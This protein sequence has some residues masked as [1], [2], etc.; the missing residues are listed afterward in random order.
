MSELGSLVAS[1]RAAAGLTQQEIANTLEL[2]QTKISRLEGGDGKLEEYVAYLEAIDTDAA[3]R[4]CHI[5]GVKWAHLAQPNL[6]NPDLD[7]LVEIEGALCRLA[8][9]KTTKKVP[10]VLVGQAELL[11]R[12]LLEFGTYLLNVDHKLVWIGEIGVGKTTGACVQAGLIT[13]PRA[14]N[15]L[16][17]VMLDTGGGRTTL[18]DVTVERGPRYALHVIP[19]SDEEVYRLA[20]EFCRGLLES[21]DK[22]DGSVTADFKPAEEVERAL[23]SMANLRRPPRRKGESTPLDPAVEL[24]KSYPD[25]EE[26]RAEVSSRLTLWRRTRKSIEFDGGD[27]AEGRR[28]LKETF[29]LINN[30]RHPEFTLPAKIRVIVPF[31]PVTGSPF[32]IT[33][34]DTRGV[35]GTSIRPDLVAHLKNNRAVTILC[36]RWGSAPEPSSQALLAHVRDTEADPSLL[37]R[38]AIL[39]LARG[40]EALSMRHDDGAAATDEWE[41]YEIKLTHVGDALR[42]VDL[43]GINCTAFDAANDDPAQLTQYLIDRIA[44]LRA[45]QA[46][47]AL[48]AVG[49]VGQ[50][51]ENVKEAQALAVL[52]DI[53]NDLQILADR[54]STPPTKARMAVQNRLLKAV[55]GL[56]ARIIWA[57]T[58]RSGRYWNFNVYQYLGDGAAANAKKNCAAAIGGIREIVE[59]RLANKEYASAKAFLNQILADV[60]NWEADY[61]NAAR[62]H[63]IATFERKLSSASVMWDKCERHYGRGGGYREE[64]AAE[65]EKWFEENELLND[66]F[67]QLLK[68]AW[69]TSII[70]PLSRAAGAIEVAGGSDVA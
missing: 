36:S 68:K 42:R 7:T 47:G 65:L 60:N 11:S 33:M 44:N 39:V 67:E 29:T 3:R 5:V 13:D 53:N 25:A 34:M 63:A 62:H 4:L 69:R 38:V 26:F 18:C 61:V 15:D 40:G 20:A 51:L 64:V 30:G 49:A 48:A 17:G 54:H 2:T 58:R 31:E 27:D 59:Q 70:E 22:R 24:A 28:W 52:Q 46:E 35:D 23:R 32:N 41:G 19:L 9:F 1:V 37:G 50:M 45:I 6:R 8:D 10:Q 16:K 14:S 57:T 56:H 55:Q 43:N 66:K 21:G 12:R